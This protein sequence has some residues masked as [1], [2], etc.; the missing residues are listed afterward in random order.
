MQK[1]GFVKRNILHIANTIFK[2]KINKAGVK[3]KP[4]PNKSCKI[5]LMFL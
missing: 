3:I 5:K 2:Q 4:E 1:S